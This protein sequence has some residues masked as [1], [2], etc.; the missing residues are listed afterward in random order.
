[1]CGPMLVHP[2]TLRETLRQAAV[3]AAREANAP[4]SAWPDRYPGRWVTARRIAEISGRRIAEVSY[5][6]AELVDDGVLIS[7]EPWPAGTRGYQPLEQNVPLFALAAPIE[8][9]RQWLLDELARWASLH[10][11]KPPRQIDWSKAN[12]PHNEWPRWDR[13]RDFFETEAVEHGLRFYEYHRCSNCTCAS[14]QHY[15]NSKGDTYCDGC[16]DC[17]GHCPY[18]PAG[19]TIGPSGWR[20]A[21]EVAGLV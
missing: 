12:D 13:V 14:G 18:G 7:T 20:Y 17:K 21:L 16:F 6:L 2:K 11:G 4:I 10:D 19:E 8:D 1:M 9:E 5:H 3:V 15:T